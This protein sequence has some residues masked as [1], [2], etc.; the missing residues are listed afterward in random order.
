MRHPPSRRAIVVALAAFTAVAT[1]AFTA[2]AIGF[3]SF[4]DVFDDSSVDGYRFGHDPSLGRPKGEHEPSRMFGDAATRGDTHSD[5]A[6]PKQP[7]IAE[8]PNELED[9]A[10]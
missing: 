7:P 6:Q 5:R 3:G 2:H 4:W 1:P 8:Q 9:R 10:G